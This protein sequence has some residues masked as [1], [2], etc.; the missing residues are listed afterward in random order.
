M[1]RVSKNISGCSLRHEVPWRSSEKFRTPAF[2]GQVSWGRGRLPPPFLF[3]GV[4]CAAS[5]RQGGARS[6]LP[7]FSCHDF[8]YH[9]SDLCP[10]GCPMGIPMG[11]P[12]SH[13]T[14]VRHSVHKVVAEKNKEGGSWHPLAWLR[15]HSQPPQTKM[16][17]AI[18]RDPMRLAP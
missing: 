2:K 6:R 5:T 8:M 9:V 1:R 4:D 14:Q 12:T 3:G 15:P 10:M 18:C 11:R 16:E 17:E 7:C 13:G